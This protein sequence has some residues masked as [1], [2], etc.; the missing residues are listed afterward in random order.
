MPK[1]QRANRLPYGQLSSPSYN[2]AKCAASNP[3]GMICAASLNS[4][5]APALA[6]FLED[7]KVGAQMK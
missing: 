5:D 1:F 2:P 7:V 4:E 6:F 3:K